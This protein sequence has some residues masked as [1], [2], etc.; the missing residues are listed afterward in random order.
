MKKVRRKALPLLALL[1]VLGAFAGVALAMSRT[2][3]APAA[4]MALAD[5]TRVGASLRTQ[6]PGQEAVQADAWAE[7]EASAQGEIGAPGRAPVPL[8]WM[9]LGGLSTAVGILVAT[10]EKKRT[11]FR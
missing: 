9:A 3:N 4:Q 2:S 5:P 10:R 1:V 8:F 11:I 6:S 7:E